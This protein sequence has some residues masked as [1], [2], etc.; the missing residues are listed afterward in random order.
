MKAWE[1]ISETKDYL[2]KLQAE[3]AE[4]VKPTVVPAAMRNDNHHMEY[5]SR[6]EFDAKIEAMEARMDGRVARIDGKLDLMMERL[7]D[8]KQSTTNLRWWLVGA[9]VTVLVA[10]VATAIG[11]QQMTVTTFQ[12][13]S[14]Q[15]AA[16]PVVI[17]VPTIPAPTPAK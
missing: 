8:A 11:I 16:A 1:D 5:V 7:Q 3:I 17:Q 9:A 15:P 4:I 13:A 6:P 14:Q 12:A 2:A 10:C